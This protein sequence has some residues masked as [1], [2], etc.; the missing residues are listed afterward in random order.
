MRS[1]LRFLV[2][3]A[4]VA[5]GV[6]VLYFW[7][8]AQPVAGDRGKNKPDHLPLLTALDREFTALVA[9]VL[10]SVVSIEAIPPDAVDPRAKLLRMMLGKN[11][12]QESPSSGSGVIVSGNGHVVT[13]LHVVAGA[14][15]VQVQ[16]ADGRT[17][18][19]KF[20]G[21]DGP[22]DIAILKIDA[23]GLR[24][25]PFGDSDAVNVGQMVIAV[26]NPLG[27]QETVTQ[28]II[29]A[30]GRRAMSEAA[31]EFFQ[32]DAAINPGNSGGP[33]VNLQGQIIGINNSISPHG[34]GIGFSIPSNTVR[35]VF[36]NIRDHGRFIRPWFGAYMRTLSPELAQQLRLPDMSGVLVILVYDGSPA[37]AGGV[38]AGDVIVAFNGKPIRDLIDLRNRV[39]ETDL[40]Q[41]VT[42]GVRRDGRELELHTVIAAEPGA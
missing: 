29:S 16:L 33:L 25:L 13:N 39:V 20:V 34:Q 37:E 18:P 17:L 3:V 21:A 19:A 38:R 41:K 23:P 30:K 1:V 35:R 31:N 26:G 6:G 32:T 2:F 22:S 8:S 15:A 11:A 36:E 10:P 7:K 9:D 27:L 5:A 12:P 14:G 24:P 4:V 40:G 42:L 28:G